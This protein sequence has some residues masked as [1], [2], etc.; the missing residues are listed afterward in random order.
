MALVLL[1]SAVDLLCNSLDDRGQCLYHL[2][3]PPYIRPLPSP[4]LRI[5]PDLLLSDVALVLLSSVVDLLCLSLDDRVLSNG[6]VLV[7]LVLGD[8]VRLY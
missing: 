6:D 8:G 3:H 5:K 4:F 2:L 1:S 7:V